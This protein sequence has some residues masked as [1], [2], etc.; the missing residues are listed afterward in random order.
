MSETD[1][2]MIS[3][4]LNL[5]GKIEL[6]LN[7]LSSRYIPTLENLSRFFETSISSIKRRLEDQDQTSYKN[8]VDRWRFVNAMK[9][10]LET[11]LKIN[12]IS[13]QLY[14]AN[15]ANFIRAFKHWIAIGPQEFRKANR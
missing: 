12:E 3:I 11:N 4:P 2:T 8:I 13:D 6:L 5:S 1:L 10:L 9:L 15:S 14:Y 7:N